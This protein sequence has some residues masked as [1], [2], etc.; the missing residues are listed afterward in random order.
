[1]PTLIHELGW[2]VY[3]VTRI[4]VARIFKWEVSCTTFSTVMMIWMVWL[5]PQR[6]IFQATSI[7]QRTVLSHHDTRI[8]PQQS[9]KGYLPLPQNFFTGFVKNSQ[10]TM[11][12]E[13]TALM[14]QTVKSI[15]IQCSQN[16]NIACTRISTVNVNYCTFKIYSARKKWRTTSGR[17]KH[18]HTQQQSSA[19]W[20]AR[21]RQNTE[22]KCLWKLEGRRRGHFIPAK[23][24]QRNLPISR[25]LLL[26]LYHHHHYFAKT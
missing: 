12:V 18:K 3:H 19:G 6:Q 13:G 26:Y 20:N 16:I 9:G 22:T 17:R 5:G 4:C 24:R 7:S 15:N 8:K 10:V 14:H 21:K 1:M 25:K 2:S 23:N 11:A